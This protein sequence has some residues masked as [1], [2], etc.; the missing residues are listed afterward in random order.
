MTKK[1]KKVNIKRI[2]VALVVMLFVV[3]IMLGTTFFNSYHCGECDISSNQYNSEVCVA[4]TVAK[5]WQNF[6]SGG[7]GNSSLALTGLTFF[8]LII[9]FILFIAFLFKTPIT[10]R[11]I[12]QN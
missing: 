9:V 7:L 3:G 12:M 2:S 5:R 8:S 11:D 1:A 10:K 4:C 6:L